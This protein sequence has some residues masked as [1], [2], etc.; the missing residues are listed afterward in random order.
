MPIPQSAGIFALKR[1]R[2]PFSLGKLSSLGSETR[3]EIEHVLCTGEIRCRFIAVQL[4]SLDSH[5]SNVVATRAISS[6]GAQKTLRAV[7]REGIYGEGRECSF[8]S[9]T[10]LSQMWSGNG[11]ISG[12]PGQRNHGP[13]SMF[14]LW[15]RGRIESRSPRDATAEAPNRGRRA[16]SP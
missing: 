12:Q 10:R 4:R 8:N 11:K 15:A 16:V 9:C 2:I 7:L 1:D 5:R 6:M 13:R 14:N 3:F